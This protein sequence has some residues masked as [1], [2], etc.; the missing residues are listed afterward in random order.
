MTLRDENVFKRRINSD[1]RDAWLLLVD[2][3]DVC[4]QANPR[5]AGDFAV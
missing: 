5:T 2:G 1:N 4:Q 3:K